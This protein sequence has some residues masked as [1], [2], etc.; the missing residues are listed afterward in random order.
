LLVTPEEGSALRLSTAFVPYEIKSIKRVL[1]DCGDCQTCVKIC[2]FLKNKK[3]YRQKCLLHL[4]NLGLENEVCG[5][6]IRVC[7][8]QLLNR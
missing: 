8:E 7:W 1:Q 5:I 4:K 3:D 6:C 2:P